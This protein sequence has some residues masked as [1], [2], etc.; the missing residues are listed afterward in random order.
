MLRDICYMLYVIYS[1]ILSR[2]INC[3]ELHRRE[4]Y[5]VASNLNFVSGNIYFPRKSVVM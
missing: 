2:S 5:I 1:T 3:Y 4:N